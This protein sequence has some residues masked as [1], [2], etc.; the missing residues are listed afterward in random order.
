MGNKEQQEQ[1]GGLELGIRIPQSF[2]SE[3]FFLEK[4]GDSCSKERKKLTNLRAKFGPAILFLRMGGGQF[5]RK[6]S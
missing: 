3:M 1:F 5:E 4:I 2:C 6:F